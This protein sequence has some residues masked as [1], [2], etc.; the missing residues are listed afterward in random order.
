[1]SKLFLILAL[2]AGLVVV[3]TGCASDP[4]SREFIPGTGW[5]PN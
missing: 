2:A 5:V 4:G 1:M 3:A